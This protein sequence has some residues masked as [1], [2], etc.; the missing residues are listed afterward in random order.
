MPRRARMYIPGMPYH[1][2]QRGNNREACFIEAENYQ[3]Y[4]ELWRQLSKRYDADVHAFCLMTNHIHFLVT[5]KTKEAI[6]NTMKVV[7]SRYAQ[8]INLK[9]KRT[10][11][12]WEGRH[13]SSLI[14]TENYLLRCYR[15]IELNPVRAG[16]VRRPEEYRW[17]SFGANGWG[18]VS[19]LTPHDEYLK[20]G[21]EDESRAKAYRSLFKEQLSE[22]NLHLFRK[23]AHYCQPVGDDRFRE[24]IEKKYGVV[25]GKMKRGR[26][27]RR[28]E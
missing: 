24:Q 25:L 17:S 14:Q 28:E 3:Y 19:W 27:K 22:E 2:V 9:Y 20:L 21:K 16:M 5:P 4:L 23:A 15:Y 13:R 11:T 12:L 1:V 18:D 8:Y 7:G 10:G 26:P 6:S